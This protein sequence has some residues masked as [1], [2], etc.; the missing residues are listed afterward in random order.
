MKRIVLYLL[1]IALCPCVSIAALGDAVDGY[2]LKDE[3]DF[4]VEWSSHTP[5]LIVDGGG[6]D[7]L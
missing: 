6:A 1:F 2:L 5:P 7:L 3:Y 4:G